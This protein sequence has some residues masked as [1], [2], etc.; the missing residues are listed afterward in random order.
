LQKNIIRLFKKIN[1]AH[2]WWF[3]MGRSSEMSSENLLL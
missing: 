1:S 3:C 2:C